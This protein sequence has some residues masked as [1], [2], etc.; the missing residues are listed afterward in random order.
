[1]GEGTRGIKDY[2]PLSTRYVY[3]TNIRWHPFRNA[4]LQ[5]NYNSMSLSSSDKYAP[6][7]SER[8]ERNL[9]AVLHINELG[10]EAYLYM[11]EFKRFSFHLGG[12]GFRY[13]YDGEAGVIGEP[14]EPYSDGGIGGSLSGF[15]SLR[16]GITRLGFGFTHRSVFHD[17][18]D[19][20]KTHRRDAYGTIHLGCMVRMPKPK[21]GTRSYRR[22]K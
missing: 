12:G 7:G 17:K 2:D 6:N 20:H 21:H 19:Q 18:L 9:M 11:G 10:L 4:Y 8:Q 13:E 5:L 16:V 22:F 1:M 14:L 3:G 15:L